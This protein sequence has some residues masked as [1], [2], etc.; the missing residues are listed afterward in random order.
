MNQ[1]RYF[2]F[3]SYSRKDLDVA[4]MIYRRLESFRYPA[5]VEKQYRPKA[6]RYVKDIFL[7]RTRLGFSQNSFHDEIRTALAQSRYLIVLCSSNSGVP[8]A[9]GRYYVNEEILYFLSQHNGDFGLIVPVLLDDVKTLPPSIN[10]ESMWA[11]NNPVCLRKNRESGVDEAVA[12]I[13]S[14]V[15]HMDSS[16]LYRRLNSQRLRRF[17]L[18]AAGCFVAAIFF[19]A[20]TAA[21]FVLKQRADASRKVADDNA[22]EAKRQYERA[23]ANAKEAERQARLAV[24]NAEK[25]EKERVLAA[26]ALDFMV[27]TFRMSDPVNAGQSDVRMVDILKA[28]IPDIARLEP[29]ELRADIGCQVGSLLHNVGLFQDATNLLFSALSLNQSRRPSSAETAYNLYCVSWC[30][31]RELSDTESALSYAKQALDIYESAPCVDQLKIALVCNAIGVFHM[32]RDG[33]LAQSRAYLNRA[34]GIRQNVLGDNHVDLAVVCCNLGHLYAKERDYE[35]AEKAYSKALHIYSDNG[36]DLHVGVARTWRGLGLSYYDS[37]EYEKAIGSF[38]KAL[39]IQ[40]KV[41][42]MDSRPV[43]NLYREIAFSHRRLGE[44]SKAVNSMSM[45]VDIARK[46]VDKDNTEANRKILRDQ[47]RFYNAMKNLREASER[48]R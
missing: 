42:G 33:E 27:D 2:A 30:F 39:E 40:I 13:L 35:L 32:D 29:W 41:A 37:G 5:K 19:S 38:K 47:E 48:R 9:D 14:Y 18:L 16:V 4:R 8:N 1:E 11:R 23:S 12:G 6:S 45:A 3:I 46:L 10:T 24:S 31:F 44:Y 36:K 22:R 7:D 43:L 25:A 17:R 21:M 34:F 20:M 26:Q 28:R 15:F